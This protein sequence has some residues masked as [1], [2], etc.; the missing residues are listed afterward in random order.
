MEFVP[1]GDELNPQRYAS[2]R[3]GKDGESEEYNEFSVG[4]VLRT[5]DNAGLK[6]LKPTHEVAFTLNGG[7]FALPPE[8]VR[9]G[10]AAKLAK[11]AELAI[12]LNG[13]KNG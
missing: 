3:Y 12:T 2:M 6:L 8:W 7:V 4:V 11:Y 9:D 1:L 5:H 13:A 10:L